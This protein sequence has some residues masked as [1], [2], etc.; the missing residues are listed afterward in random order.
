MRQIFVFSYIFCI[1]VCPTLYSSS[2]FTS[3]LFFYRKKRFLKIPVSMKPLQNQ[4][5]TNDSKL[6]C[7]H[8]VLSIRIFVLQEILPAITQQ[9]EIQ[10]ALRMQIDNLESQKMLLEMEK[11][12]VTK[13]YQ[14]LKYHG[15]KKTS[16]WVYKNQC[17]IIQYVTLY[18][19]TI[20]Y[21]LTNR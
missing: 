13:E 15:E 19:E 1:Y 17:R 4:L 3:I 14:R 12:G 11:A 7:K 21:I 18:R 2:V 9:H 8:N 20:K 5:L 10:R 6:I 16:E